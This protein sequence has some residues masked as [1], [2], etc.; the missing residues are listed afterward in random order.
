MDAPPGPMRIRALDTG[1]AA[2]Y[3]VSLKRTKKEPNFR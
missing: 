3:P 2:L 1:P